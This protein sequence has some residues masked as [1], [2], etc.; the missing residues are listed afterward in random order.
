MRLIALASATAL[1]AACSS[2]TAETE[3]V[4]AAPAPV[5]TAS[6]TG[7][8]GAETPAAETRVAA[9]LSYAD[10]CGSCK[11]LDPKIEA[12]KAA[13]VPDGVG[14]VT[15]DYTD[16][17]GDAFFAGADAA[18][19]GEAIRTFYAD[20]VKTG[21]LLLIDTET[22]TVLADIRKTMSV[23]EIDAAIKSAAEAA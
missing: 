14:F 7:A 13:G 15:L 11:T 9:V 20:E 21:I 22:N 5:E 6:T 12:V 23:E 2:E 8:E 1:L 3:V 18:G 19:V 16:R 4:E 10:W 17:D